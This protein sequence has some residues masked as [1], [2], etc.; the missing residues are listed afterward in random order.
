MLPAPGGGRRRAVH[1]GWGRNP[2]PA[3]AEPA[4]HR[5]LGHPH[6]RHA[7]PRRRAAQPTARRSDGPHCGG[8]VRS[9]RMPRVPAHSAHR[10]ADS[11][12]LAAR[13]RGRRWPHRR[14]YSGSIAGRHGTA[15]RRRTRF[16]VGRVRAVPPGGVEFARCMERAGVAG[17]PAV[18]AVTRL[19]AEL[20]R[21]RA[22]AANSRAR[23]AAVLVTGP[24]GLCFLPAFLALG[25]APVLECRLDAHRVVATGV[26][27]P[28]AGVMGTRISGRVPADRLSRARWASF[29]ELPEHDEGKG[30][31][32][33]SLS[34]CHVL[35][36]AAIQPPPPGPT[37]WNR[38]E[39]TWPPGSTLRASGSFAVSGGLQHASVEQ[40]GAQDVA[41]VG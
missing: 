12:V 14:P 26:V 16:G 39:I 11:A 40:V 5:R 17:V 38:G 20:R 7:R 35:Q 18:K 21:R 4:V 30:D 25:V 24:L 9:R 37:G 29:P 41:G 36:P 28:Y 2:L 10:R 23:R 27:R 13:Y 8:T 22:R 34:R 3:V 6:Q 15:A 31:V 32:G 19:A 33:D 1:S